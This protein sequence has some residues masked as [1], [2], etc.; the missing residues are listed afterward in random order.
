[1]Q[2][3]LNRYIETDAK[4]KGALIGIS[5][6]SAISGDV[7]YEYNHDIRLHPASNMKLLTAAAALNVLGRDYTFS[8][9]LQT[10]GVLKEGTLE[11]NLF[12]VGKG[13]PTLLTEDFETF[14]EKIKKKGIHKITGDI[15]GDDTWYDHVRLSRDLVWSDEQYYYGAEVSALTASPNKD[16]DTGSVLIEVTPTV[17]GEHPTFTISPDTDYVMVRNRAITVEEALDDDLIVERDHGSNRI[18][19]S[20][21]IAHASEKVKQ[22]MSVWGASEYAMRLFS[23]ALTKQGIGWDGE[24]K[25]GVAPRNATVLSSKDSVPLSEILIPFMKLSNNGIAEML[26]KEMGRRLQKEGSWESGIPVLEKEME[27]LGIAVKHLLIK[28][29]SGISHSNLIPANEISQLL[30]E[31]QKKDWFPVFLHALPVSGHPDRMIGGTLHERMKVFSVQAKTGTIEGVSTL[32]GYLDIPN[33][34]RLIFSIMVNNLLDEEVGK[35][36]EDEIVERIVAEGK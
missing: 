15:I 3:T 4:L 6:R 12:L 9:Q 26:I 30:Y 10:D 27:E 7:L 19:I 21:K 16:Y 34:E 13:D 23:D 35:V 18:T 20:G 28:D 36:I 14:A 29:G 24:V 11:G 22:W 5:I 17:I 2:E 25:I 33:G 31:V 32:S 8:T 1:M